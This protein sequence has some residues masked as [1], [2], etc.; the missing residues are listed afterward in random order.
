MRDKINSIIINNIAPL[1]EVWSVKANLD[2]TERIVLYDKLFNP[3]MPTEID[4]AKKIFVDER[5]VRRIWKKVRN[6]I[7]KILP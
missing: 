7:Y 6:K 1:Y 3:D 5:T 4:I 2:E